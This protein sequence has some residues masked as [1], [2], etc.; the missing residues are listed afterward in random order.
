MGRPTLTVLDHPLYARD[1]LA[2]P[3]IPSGGGGLFSTVTDYGRFAQMLLNKGELEGRRILKASSV[4][5]MATNHLSPA[6]LERG[7]EAGMQHIRQGFGYGYNGA[8]CDDPVLAKADVGAGTYQWDGASGVWFWVDPENDLIF[9]GMIQ[10]MMQEGMPRLQAM[11]QRMV[12]EA[13]A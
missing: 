4:E 12:K 6:I 1:G 8:V 10:R 9:V 2:I 5:T 7:V 13:M 11:T 3:K